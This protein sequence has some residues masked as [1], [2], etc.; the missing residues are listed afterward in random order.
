MYYPF[1]TR[2]SQSRGA[3]N[4]RDRELH[5]LSS[6]TSSASD[7]L[8]SSTAFDTSLDSS[9]TS[10]TNESLSFCEENKNKG[11]LKEVPIVK[12]INTNMGGNCPQTN[13]DQRT[14]RSVPTIK[15][16]PD[17][18]ILVLD[19]DNLRPSAESTPRKE[20]TPPRSGKRKRETSPQEDRA[21]QIHTA[22]VHPPPS[23]NSERVSTSRCTTTPA[24]KRKHSSGGGGPSAKI[25]RVKH[26]NLFDSIS[27]IV[28]IKKEKPDVIEI[29]D[30]DDENERNGDDQELEQRNESDEENSD[31]DGDVLIPVYVRKSELE[32]KGFELESTK[33]EI[34]VVSLG[35]SSQN[36]Q[37]SGKK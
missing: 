10:G 2:M 8:S 29:K 16:E 36:G 13:R 30:S 3:G 32:E 27:D 22:E 31:S 14:S 25:G 35:K 33:N 20:D 17:D 21:E 23:S 11:V 24:K 26:E 19:D 37:G 4:Y 18:D 34:G 7:P 12:D 6:D 28:E 9:T 15:R 1:Q 5:S